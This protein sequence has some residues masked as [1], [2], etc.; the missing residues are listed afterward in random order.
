M[1]WPWKF[2]ELRQKLVL[3]PKEKRVIIFILLVFALG[4]ATKCYRESHRQP[5]QP[6]D[7]KHGLQQQVTPVS[8]PEKKHTRGRKL[9]KPS[10]TPTMPA[11]SPSGYSPR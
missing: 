10:A 7:S 6:R 4:L 8:S 5:L 11:N 1:R 3:T 2:G 9:R